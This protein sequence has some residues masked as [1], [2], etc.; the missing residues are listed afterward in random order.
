M[1]RDAWS[2]AFP[3]VTSLI[4]TVDELS[5]YHMHIYIFPLY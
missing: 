2:N 5:E 1:S 4:H 3:Q